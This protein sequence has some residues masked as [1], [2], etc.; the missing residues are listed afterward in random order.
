MDG[1]DLQSIY[2][3]QFHQITDPEQ[4][5]LFI[6][7]R[8]QPICWHLQQSKEYPR[9]IYCPY[10]R[11]DGRSRIFTCFDFNKLTFTPP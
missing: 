10:K 8:Q 4:Q 7:K 6:V 3:Q 5:E 1:K 2:W 11:C 9:P